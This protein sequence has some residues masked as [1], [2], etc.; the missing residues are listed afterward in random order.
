MTLKQIAA[1]YNKT[2]KTF[3]RHVRALK[4]PHE[5]LGRSMIFDPVAV[6]AHLSAKFEPDNILKFKP[7]GIKSRTRKSKF[8]EAI[9]L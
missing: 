1:L 3:A 5:K 7:K 6:S 8:A 9:G 4:I 2:P